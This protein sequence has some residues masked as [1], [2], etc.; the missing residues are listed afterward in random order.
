MGCLFCDFINGKKNHTLD[1][2]FIKEKPPYPLISIFENEY[3]FSF[4]SIP[5]N[6]GES[7]VL[8]IPK[9]HSEFIENLSERFL[10]K[11]FP[12]VVKMAGIIR[13]K[14]GDCHILLNNG[15]NA[16]QYIKH[17]HF[18]IIPK[19]SKKKIIW[20]DLSSNQFEK[21]SKE[22]IPLFKQLH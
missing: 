7:H 9:E 8:V 21:L 10:E 11:I 20:H 22:L 2:K 13:K 3:I 14:Y 15:K 19:N 6:T 17:V 4:L 18:H 1:S 5:D 12:L 16:D